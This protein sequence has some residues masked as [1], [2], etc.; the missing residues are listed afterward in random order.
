MFVA[1]LSLPFVI[2][3]YSAVAFIVMAVIFSA[4][5]LASKGLEALGNA[6]AQDDEEEE[7]VTEHEGSV[8]E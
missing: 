7:D 8:R 2:L 3:G 6:L 4:L 5:W 1:M